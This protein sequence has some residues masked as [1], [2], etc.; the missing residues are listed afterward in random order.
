MEAAARYPLL[1]ECGACIIGAIGFS[2]L[3]NV[4]GWG[5]WLCV[6]GSVL[7]WA[8]YCVLL[9]LATADTFAFFVASVFAS[10]YFELMAR[11][12]KYP[13]ISYLVV[14]IFPLL[15]GGDIYYTINYAVQ[16]DMVN[17]SQWGDAHHRRGRVHGRGYPAGGD[18][19]PP[20]QQPEKGP[21]RLS[22]S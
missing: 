6:L 2:I 9:R 21:Q 13:A 11:I 20:D 19:C 7:S 8:V 15:P 4:H 10:C 18:G 17:F 3:F 5:M 1:L 14:S 12:L 16:G 22:V